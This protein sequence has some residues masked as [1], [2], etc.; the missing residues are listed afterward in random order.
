MNYILQSSFFSNIILCI[1]L[2]KCKIYW[3]FVNF[4][5][6]VFKWMQMNYGGRCESLNAIRQQAMLCGTQRFL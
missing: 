3:A 4:N 5:Q 1:Q 2:R 6:A